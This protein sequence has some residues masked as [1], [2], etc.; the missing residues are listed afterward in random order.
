MIRPVRCKVGPCESGCH[1]KATEFM[2]TLRLHTRRRS[3]EKLDKFGIRDYIQAPVLVAR[4]FLIIWPA[5]FD[6]S[7][8]QNNVLRTINPRA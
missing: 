2:L 1:E 8:D 5:P 7:N 4:D 6:S 3:I